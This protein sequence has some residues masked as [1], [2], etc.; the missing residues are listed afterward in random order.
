MPRSSYDPAVYTYP[1]K[2]IKEK[3]VAKKL[4][5]YT[6]VEDREEWR[7]WLTFAVAPVATAAKRS[8]KSK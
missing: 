4:D 3:V 7:T 2:E 8:R 6:E 5:Q 1:I